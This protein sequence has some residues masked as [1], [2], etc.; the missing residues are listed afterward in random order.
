M[1]NIVSNQIKSNIDYWK[2]EIEKEV[3]LKDNLYKN[4]VCILIT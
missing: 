1:K 2:G 3:R 4:N